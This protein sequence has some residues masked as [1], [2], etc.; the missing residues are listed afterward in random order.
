MTKESRKKIKKMIYISRGNVPSRAANALQTMK[1]ASA[2]S[3]LINDFRLLINVSIFNFINF[4]KRFDLFDFYNIDKLKLSKI[5]CSF[6][7]EVFFSSNYGSKLFTNLAPFYTKFK[8]PEVVYVRKLDIARR[9]LRLGSNVVLECHTEL[10]EKYI[11]S[12]EFSTMNF[13][14]CITI[15][16]RL[17]DSNISKGMP[18]EKI[19]VEQDGVSLSEY[20]IKEDKLDIRKKMNLPIDKYILTYS[21][22]LHDFKGIPLILKAAKEFKDDLFLLI[23]GWEHDIKRV[24]SEC[25]KQKINNVICYGYVK[26]RLIPRMLYASDLLLLPT[27]FKHK[28]SKDTSPLKM[29]EYM[30]SGRPIIASNLDNISLILKNEINALLFEPDSFES[31]EEKI[32]FMKDNEENAKLLTSQAKLDV[33]YYEWNKRAER[34]IK[35]I[36]SRMFG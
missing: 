7:R 1:M 22:H 12:K 32:L 11:R 30:A 2:F 35:F 3:K 21:G 6:N 9:C 18:P 36:E 24:K 19:I 26:P 34:I 31:L 8:R 10:P 16:H 25:R 20:K 33:E 27:S 4:S 15:S 17:R 13:L 14:G 23:G 28:W 29:F 5:P